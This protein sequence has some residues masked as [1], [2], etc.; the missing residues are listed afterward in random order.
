MAAPVIN[1]PAVT[2][3]RYSRRGGLEWAALG[4]VLNEPLLVDAA[5]EELA[6]SLHALFEAP[7][8]PNWRNEAVTDR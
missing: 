5:G 7:G 8:G 1:T 6:Y 3:E 4:A 2:V